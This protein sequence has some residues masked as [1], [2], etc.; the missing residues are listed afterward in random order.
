M[1]RETGGRRNTTAGRLHEK[2]SRKGG[3]ENKI[4]HF[5]RHLHSQHVNQ[6]VFINR[7]ENVQLRFFGE[8]EVGA[9]VVRLPLVGQW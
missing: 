8:K 6:A 3:Y 4:I 9:V 5:L 1:K 2:L 7:F